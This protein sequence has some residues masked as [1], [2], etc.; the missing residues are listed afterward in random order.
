MQAEGTVS[1]DPEPEPEPEPE[2]L[3]VGSAFKQEQSAEAQADEQLSIAVHP[4]VGSSFA[5][6]ESM[7]A[8][9]APAMSSEE[10]P[11]ST[12]S[13]LSPQ[14]SLQLRNNT[15][16][17]QE[18]SLPECS[19]QPAQEQATAAHEDGP[20]QEVRT[21][22][23]KS[24]SQQAAPKSTMRKAPKQ[25]S[26]GKPNQGTSPS[27]LPPLGKSQAAAQHP[28]QALLD[29]GKA[30]APSH[31]AVGVAAAGRWPKQ[32]EQPPQPRS[33][34]PPLHPWPQELPTSMQRGS[35]QVASADHARE[36]RIIWLLSR[37]FIQACYHAS[38]DS[39]QCHIAISAVYTPVASVRLQMNADEKKLKWQVL[40]DDAGMCLQ[41][42]KA[43]F[44]A[45]GDRD[46]DE[47]LCVVCWERA[48]EVIFYHCM[49]M[50][51]SCSTK[52]YYCS[53]ATH[54]QC[55]AVSC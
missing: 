11:S 31:A 12:G 53:S 23:R 45:E 41:A 43:D 5:A 2:L 49:H 54:R 36:V 42:A 29:P 35:L 18:G 34:D 33:P 20:W 24:A 15:S 19:A 25:G 40:Y 46:D 32:P 1:K 13:S 3:D 10:A 8:D 7:P 26:S 37:C 52:T 50:V 51:R 44:A 55:A 39:H 38:G 16:H 14:P 4:I 30:G 28:E 27:P 9:S 6:L 48:P 21:S 22:R 17:G 47:E